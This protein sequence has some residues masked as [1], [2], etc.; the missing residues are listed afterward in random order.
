MSQDLTL[1]PKRETSLL[2]HV[3]LI[4]VHVHVCYLKPIKRYGGSP[5]MGQVSLACSLCTVQLMTKCHARSWNDRQWCS[6]AIF[7]I[8]F[9]FLKN[10]KNYNPTDS[11]LEYA[12]VL[13]SVRCDLKETDLSGGKL[14][15]FNTPFLCLRTS[16]QLCLFKPPFPHANLDELATPLFPQTPL[17]TPRVLTRSPMIPWKN[18]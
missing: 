9:H 14:L 4:E 1:I 15:N 7:L 10:W 2:V 6:R 3:Y 13:P 8:N 16:T 5:L 12:P 17:P 18:K 11:S